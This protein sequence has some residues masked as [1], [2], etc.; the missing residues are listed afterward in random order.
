MQYRSRQISIVAV[1]VLG[2]VLVA[3]VAFRRS[4]VVE[5]VPESISLVQRTRLGGEE[6]GSKRNTVRRQE[7]AKR[8]ET[9]RN[10]ETEATFEKI[11]QAIAYGSDTEVVQAV[12]QAP[13]LDLGQRIALANMGLDAIGDP[14]LR[15]DLVIS[16]SEVGTKKVLP[17]ILKALK[18]EDPFVRSQALYA[19][20]QF[21]NI[22]DMELEPWLKENLEEG[23]ELSNEL[24]ENELAKIGENIE[25]AEWDDF[26]QALLE[27]F[28]DKDASVRED[29]MDLMLKLRGD[30]RLQAV[31]TALQSDYED[32]QMEALRIAS[33][34][35]S[36]QMFDVLLLGMESENNEVSSKAQYYAEDI[37]NQK[38]QNA[39]EAKQW[40]QEHSEDYNPAMV[41]SQESLEK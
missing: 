21:C 9:A 2:L 38:F 4:S 27:A 29:A 23:E 39:N 25:E 19:L 31:E 33:G 20:G 18:D 7:L 10:S 16:V 36:K 26:S 6:E 1:V 22:R 41:Q 14:W 5:E 35:R 17:T 3:F 11:Q 40:W 12:S 24:V 34:D 15:R 30:M 8:W 13:A 28:N 32:T 37:V